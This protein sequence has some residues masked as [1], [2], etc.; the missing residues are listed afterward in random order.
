MG[1]SAFAADYNAEDNLNIIVQAEC[2]AQQSL[3]EVG[4]CDDVMLNRDLQTAGG[5]YDT[6][7]SAIGYIDA[8]LKSLNMPGSALGCAQTGDTVGYL[9]PAGPGCAVAAAHLAELLKRYKSAATTATTKATLTKTTTTTTFDK[10]LELECEENKDKK[11]QKEGSML[12]FFQVITLETCKAKC[13]DRNTCNTYTH[14]SAYYG[15]CELYSSSAPA[16][17]SQV[18]ATTF[19]CT[20]LDYTTTTTTKTPLSTPTTATTTTP[21]SS[22]KFVCTDNTRSIANTGNKLEVAQQLTFE[23]CKAACADL[24]ACKTFDF[25]EEYSDDDDTYWVPSSCDLWSDAEQLE[26]SSG[27]EHCVKVAEDTPIGMTC[28]KGSFATAA[29]EIFIAFPQRR[30]C[31]YAVDRINTMIGTTFGCNSHGSTYYLGGPGCDASIGKLIAA[32]EPSGAAQKLGDSLDRPSC[33]WSIMTVGNFARWTCKDGKELKCPE[34]IAES[35]EPA[36]AFLEELLKPA[37]TSTSVT[38]A[39]TT[40]TTTKVPLTTTTTTTTFDNALDLKCEAYKDQ[41]FPKEPIYETKGDTLEA[42][43]AACI[44]RNKCKSYTFHSLIKVCQLHEQNDSRDLVDDVRFGA[45][46]YIC[47]RLR[48]TTA[49]TNALCTSSSIKD[50]CGPHFDFAWCKYET[51]PYCNELNG[52]CGETVNHRDAQA[53]TQ[54]DWRAEEESQVDLSTT[55]TETTASNNP[56]AGG[57]GAVSMTTTPAAAT[58]QTTI[59]NATTPPEAATTQT[60][61]IN[62]QQPSSSSSTGTTT[63]V[64]VVLVALILLAVVVALC[65][66]YC[67]DQKHQIPAMAAA[68]APNPAYAHGE[69]GNDAANVAAGDFALYMGPD[70]LQPDVY[71]KLKQERLQQEQE[72]QQQQQQQQRRNT[73]TASENDITYAIPFDE[74]GDDGAGYA[75]PI[76]DYIASGG[77]SDAA[78]TYALPTARLPLDMDGYVVD[79]T[80]P[81]S[82]GGAAPV[83]AIA[84]P[85]NSVV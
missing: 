80:A 40:T 74:G 27:I 38:T 78:P 25:E 83:Y 10:T 79:D 75:V 26:Y 64:V 49:A 85:D 11:V 65:V 56:K 68:Y 19:T 67:N 69:N 9:K 34:T 20:R 30:A 33:W 66:Y 50:C 62:A 54:Y 71:D 46:T 45:I 41:I 53:S 16:L 22:S 77:G 51:T 24:A 23:E 31:E 35:C 15:A 8:A 44:A 52:Y 12:F 81:P 6:C 70:A 82:G 13:I 36:L 21:L 42:C 73:I 43:K 58:T 61:I 14:T 60:T 28:E 63:K 2:E 84:A 48:D 76:S 37:T 1:S 18:G 72:Q 55:A 32:L 17:T 59:L 7:K 39:T 57:G 4:K 3:A 29:D 5:T 47:E